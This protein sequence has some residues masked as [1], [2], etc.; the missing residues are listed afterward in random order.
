MKPFILYATPP[1]TTIIMIIII[2]F[3]Y[4]RGIV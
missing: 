4:E 2:V 3:A 1:K